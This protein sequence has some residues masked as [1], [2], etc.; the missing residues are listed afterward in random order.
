MKLKQSLKELL[1]K[2]INSYSTILDLVPSYLL[3]IRIRN[4]ALW[5]KQ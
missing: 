1:Q 3:Y 5:E 2:K 4:Y